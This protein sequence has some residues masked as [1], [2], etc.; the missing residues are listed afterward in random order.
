MGFF[1]FFSS[2]ESIA[3]SVSGFIHLIFCGIQRGTAAALDEEKE[4]S[5]DPK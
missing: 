4:N 5:T 2:V 3:L 1:F